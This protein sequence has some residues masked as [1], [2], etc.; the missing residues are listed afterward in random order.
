MMK[1]FSETWN[2]W[3]KYRLFQ[4]TRIFGNTMY[5]TKPSWVSKQI[6][7]FGIHEKVATNFVL[8]T[9]KKMI[10]VLTLVQI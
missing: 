10:F 9:I 5:L 1:K 2:F 7:R 8:K 6:A 3:L 4:K